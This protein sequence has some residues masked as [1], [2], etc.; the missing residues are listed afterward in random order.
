MGADKC[1]SSLISDRD[2]VEIVIGGA[3]RMATAPYG[4]QVRSEG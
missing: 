2:R 1:V 4:K 3:A